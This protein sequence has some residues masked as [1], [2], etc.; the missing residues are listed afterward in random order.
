MNR[1]IASNGLFSEKKSKHISLSFALMKK[2]IKEEWNFG[3]L[4]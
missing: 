2:Y 1:V 3:S 4:L